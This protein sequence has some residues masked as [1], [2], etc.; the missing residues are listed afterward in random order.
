MSTPGG[1]EH[2]PRSDAHPVRNRLGIAPLHYTSLAESSTDDAERL[3]RVV[4][5]GLR[6]GPLLEAQAPG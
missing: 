4:A 1:A 5:R 2:K 3:E 6:P